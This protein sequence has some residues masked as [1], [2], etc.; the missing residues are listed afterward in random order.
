MLTDKCKKQ[1]KKLLHERYNIVCHRIVQAQEQAYYYFYFT[2]ICSCDG[3]GFEMTLTVSRHMRYPTVLRMNLALEHVQPD[4][5]GDEFI[6]D[7]DFTLHI[8]NK[9]TH[10]INTL[11]KHMYDNPVVNSINTINQ[12]FSLGID[13]KCYIL[14]TKIIPIFGIMKKEKGWFNIKTVN[15]D[16]YLAGNLCSSFMHPRRDTPINAVL[17]NFF[18]FGDQFNHITSKKSANP[19][20]HTVAFLSVNQETLHDFEKAIFQEMFF[21]YSDLFN[22]EIEGMSQD[23]LR[24]LEIEDFLKYIEVQK[25]AQI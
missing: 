23:D 2:L 3:K 5:E 24:E 14:Y 16:A 12:K 9:N 22:F 18:V 10:L 7:Y 20:N 19:E 1:L 11:S 21:A 17:F 8:D 15:N 6:D 13:S 25:M 4:I